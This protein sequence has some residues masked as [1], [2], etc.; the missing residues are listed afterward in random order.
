MT[1][2][3]APPLRLDPWSYESLRQRILRRDNWRCQ[4]ARCRILRYTTWSSAAI[5][6]RFRRKLDHAL[7]AVP[8]PYASSRCE[9]KIARSDNENYLI[10]S[11]TK[12][13]CQ[14]DTQD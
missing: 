13:F 14:D 8:P 3:K 4:V 7:R 9:N 10:R 11:R 6:S 12:R 2:F 5:G 1:R